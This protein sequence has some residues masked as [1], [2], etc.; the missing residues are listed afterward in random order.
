MIRVCLFVLLFS[1]LGY[2]HAQQT[3]DFG[4]FV[5]INVLELGA[6]ENPN[7]L[8]LADVGG[9]RFAEMLVENRGVYAPWVG[10]SPDG[11]HFAYLAPARRGMNYEA[12]IGR[13]NIEAPN[14]YPP[15]FDL[16]LTVLSA[17]WNPTYNILATATQSANARDGLYLVNAN[18]GNVVFLREE[19]FSH[20]PLLDWAHDAY[21]LAYSNVFTQTHIINTD[22]RGT[23][24]LLAETLPLPRA[25]KGATGWTSDDAYF[26]FTDEIYQGVF[27]VQTDGS[28]RAFSFSADFV[29]DPFNIQMIPDSTRLA[30]VYGAD[31]LVM[32]L[33]TGAVQQFTLPIEAEPIYTIAANILVLDTYTV[34]AG[35]SYRECWLFDLGLGRALRL[36]EALN[37]PAW[38]HTRCL[39]LEGGAYVAVMVSENPASYDALPQDFQ[40]YLVPITLENPLQVSSSFAGFEVARPSFSP[41]WEQLVFREGNELIVANL[42]GQRMTLVTLS[43]LKIQSDFVEFDYTWQP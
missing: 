23:T 17:Q 26:V 13:P 29:A 6:A 3:D 37:Q 1:L 35:K 2:S 39:A 5:L 32:D 25:V 30:A 18:F 38:R 33:A 40:L 42:H 4:G 21:R 19:Q 31:V 16:N 14:V 43:E 11:A 22:G 10:W 28:G 27:A 36:A 20:A 41:K 7:R 12:W 9:R 15:L 24:P 8:F 34:T